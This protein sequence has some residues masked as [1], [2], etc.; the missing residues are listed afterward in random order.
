MRFYTEKEAASLMNQW[1]KERQPFLFIVDYDIKRIFVERL[2]QITP[3]VLLYD[4]N[5]LTNV[6]GRNV[7]QEHPFHAPSCMLEIHPTDKEE[8]RKSFEIVRNH[9]LAGNS[10]LT[11]LTCATPIEM[12]TSLVDLFY[13]TEAKYRLCVP[14]QFVVFSPEIFVRIQD[15]FI[16]SYPM[17][18]TISASVPNAREVIMAD[19]KESAEHATIVDL[20]RN[21]LSQISIHVSVPHYRYIDEIH[22]QTGEILLQVSSEVKGQLSEGWQQSLGDILFSLLPAGSITGAPKRKTV[23]II[24]EAETYQRGFYTGVMGVFNGETLDSAVM[25]RFIEQT[26]NGFFFKSGGGIMA[27]SECA[28]EYEEINQKIYIPLKQ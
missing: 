1:G 2:E 14:G 28:K 12:Q 22:T 4:F 9:I 17:K 8:Y 13:L 23:Q 16:C 20:I 26:K 3:D 18:G 19:V 27:K 10:Y 25:I 11:N 15:G 24:H 6:D 21:D 7:E 5:G